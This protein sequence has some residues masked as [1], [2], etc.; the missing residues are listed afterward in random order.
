MLLGAATIELAFSAVVLFV[1]PV[2]RQ[3]GH[4][5]PVAAGWGVAVDWYEKRRRAWRGQLTL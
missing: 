1:G 5:A 4:Q 2:A 3:L